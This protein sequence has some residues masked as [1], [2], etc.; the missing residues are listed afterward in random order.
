MRDERRETRGLHRGGGD[1]GLEVLLAG[2][3]YTPMHPLLHH[4]PPPWLKA[5]PRVSR[6]RSPLS[7]YCWLEAPWVRGLQERVL[8]GVEG[9]SGTTE[10][11]GLVSGV[12]EG[13]NMRAPEVEWVS[14]QVVFSVLLHFPTSLTH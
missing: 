14:L 1:P 10:Q 2:Q 5:A 6:C 8:L 13:G 4:T 9:V 3:H 12:E 7:T 11:L